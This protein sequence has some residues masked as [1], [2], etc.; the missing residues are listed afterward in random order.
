MQSSW[1]RF[2]IRDLLLATTL[3][4][5]WLAGSLY[6]QDLLKPGDLAKESPGIIAVFVLYLI[7]FEAV[8][9][10]VRRSAA[11]YLFE[12]ATEIPWPQL[13]AAAALVLAFAFLPTYPLEGAYFVVSIPFVTLVLLSICHR[14]AYVNANGVFYQLMLFQWCTIHRLPPEDDTLR[15]RLGPTWMGVT[16]DVPTQYHPQVCDLMVSGDRDETLP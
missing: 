7:I 3:L 9:R 11:P 14:T 5:I 10:L 12:F 6:A 2:R 8:Y 15:L 16:L 4:A 13:Y 1:M